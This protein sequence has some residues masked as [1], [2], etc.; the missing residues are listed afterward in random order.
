ME[1]FINFSCKLFIGDNIEYEP[2][3]YSCSRII[4]ACFLV[5]LYFDY[6]FVL[7][8]TPELGLRVISYVYVSIYCMGQPFDVL[9]KS[10]RENFLHYMKGFCTPSYFNLCVDL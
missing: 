2:S 5:E 4:L 8:L 1:I 7:G 6:D 3:F 9:T 10:H